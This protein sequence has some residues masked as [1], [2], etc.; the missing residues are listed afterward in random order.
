MGS[1]C[2]DPRFLDS[3]KICK[4]VKDYFLSEHQGVNMIAAVFCSIAN[5]AFTA[6]E[7]LVLVFLVMSMLI[8]I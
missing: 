8:C 2:I 4:I 5:S 1:G 3:L 7:S 6:V